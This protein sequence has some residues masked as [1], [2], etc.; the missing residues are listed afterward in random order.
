MDPANDGIS[1]ALETVLDRFGGR[2]RGVGFR[3]GLMG[4]DVDDLLQEVRVRLWKALQNGENIEAA[5]ASYIY[6]TAASAALDLLRRRRARRETPVRL[7]R[8][9]GEAILG[10][11][12]APD[13][14]LEGS[15][16]AER[17][18]EAVSRLADARRSV[19]RMHLAGYDRQEIADLLGWTEP[20]TRNL[21]YRGLNDL[22]ET[23]TNMGIGP[24]AVG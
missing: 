11:S 18:G 16:L 3:H 9:S 2:V 6:R 20:K 1:E 5:P 12:P 15:E 21:L 14:S 22:R 23:L 17:I 8:A 4:R 24:E 19:V 7:S 13:A 10:E